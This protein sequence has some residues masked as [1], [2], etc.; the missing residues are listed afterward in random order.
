MWESLLWL[1][2]CSYSTDVAELTS[3]T[4]L[5]LAHSQTESNLI[6]FPLILVLASVLVPLRTLHEA[7]EGV[8]GG[9]ESFRGR[10]CL[11]GQDK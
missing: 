10:A 3:S 11:P 5:F 8:L 7:S 1:F 2:S 9:L 6:G 4:L